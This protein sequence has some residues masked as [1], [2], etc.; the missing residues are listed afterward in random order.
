M[1]NGA[2][3]P[4]VHAPSHLMS[5]LPPPPSSFHMAKMKIFKELINSGI[6]SAA[7]SSDFV[8]KINRI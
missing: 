8:L 3:L 6:L 7:P 5:V 1:G 2:Q 4:I